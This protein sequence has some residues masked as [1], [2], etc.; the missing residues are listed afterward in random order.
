MAIEKPLKLFKDRTILKR[1]TIKGSSRCFRSVAPI[2]CKKQV[3][4]QIKR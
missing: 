4:K 2:Y 3:S 1:T